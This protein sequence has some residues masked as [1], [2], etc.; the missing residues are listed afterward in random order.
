MWSNAEGDVR[1]RVK[2]PSGLTCTEIRLRFVLD[3]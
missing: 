2:A 1:V 3:A